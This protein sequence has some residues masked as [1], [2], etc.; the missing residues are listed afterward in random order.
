MIAYREG[1][2]Q[3]A[4]DGFTAARHAFLTDGNVS[5]AA[6]MGSNLCVVL[7]WD[8]RP[9]EALSAVE[10]SPAVF[11]SIG[12]K[13][14]A[15]QAYGNL[16]SAREAC[17]DSIGAE[18]AYHQAAEIFKSLEEKNQYSYTMQALSRLQLRQGRHLEAIVSLQRAIE[19]KPQS[20]IKDRLLR[21]LLKLPSRL[22]NR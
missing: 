16:G 12:D 9:H 10:G 8:G 6:E 18:K 1:R 14:H 5:K 19:A 3:E 21:R 17:G 20:G 7:L 22:L 2:L 4:I 15:A 11:L 13:N